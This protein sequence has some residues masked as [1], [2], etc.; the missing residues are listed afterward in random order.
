VAYD[1]LLANLGLLIAR[2][3]HLHAAGFDS[4]DRLPLT[5]LALACCRRPSGAR[6]PALPV[7]L[8]LVDGDG[9][10]EQQAVE[11]HRVAQRGDLVGPFVCDFEH[12]FSH[13]SVVE[14]AEAGEPFHAEPL[15]LSATFS[16]FFFIVA[17]IAG[18]GLVLVFTSF[19]DT[20]IIAVVIVT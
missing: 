1:H 14:V 7:S 4:F 12:G 19:V 6:A 8:L 11:E 18:L 10:A 20:A 17:V 3:F 16:S 9:D 15:P 2:L 13:L 5:C